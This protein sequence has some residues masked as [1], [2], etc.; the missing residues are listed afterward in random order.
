ML[1]YVWLQG[2]GGG[3]GKI[4]LV[5]LAGS[6]RLVGQDVQTPTAIPR[7]L[8][9]SLRAT[10]WVGAAG[11]TMRHLSQVDSGTKHRQT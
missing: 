8:V 5:D 7:Y 1:G 11:Q 6:E 10:R 4:S 2:A 9:T 3:T